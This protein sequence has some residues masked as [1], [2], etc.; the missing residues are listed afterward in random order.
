MIVMNTD[1][2]FTETFKNTFKE[3]LLILVQ[4]VARGNQK[5]KD[6]KRFI[7]Y[8]KKVQKINSLEKGSLHQ[9]FQGVFLH[10]MIGMKSQ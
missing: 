7:Q 9:W 10:C 4:T 1:G 2:L 8:L 5:G 6:K 3:T